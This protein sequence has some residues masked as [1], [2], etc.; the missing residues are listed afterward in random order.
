[1]SRQIDMTAAATV[2][3]TARFPPATQASDSTLHEHITMTMEI[4]YSKTRILP[5]LSMSQHKPP[6]HLDL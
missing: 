6:M 4:T 2:R 1:M 3:A 5:I